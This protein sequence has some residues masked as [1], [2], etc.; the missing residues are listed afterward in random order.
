LEGS[1]CFETPATCLVITHVSIVK[2]WAGGQHNI[3]M[4][5]KEIPSEDAK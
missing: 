5:F 3:K 4:D 1:E 2:E